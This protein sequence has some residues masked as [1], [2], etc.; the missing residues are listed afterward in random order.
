MA[1]AQ[2]RDTRAFC[3]AP[4][5]RRIALPGD[6]S[7]AGA[8]AF[9]SSLARVSLVLV[10]LFLL[11]SVHPGRLLPRPQFEVQT[12]YPKIGVHTRLTDEVEEWKIEKTLAMVREMGA[13]WIVE[14]FPWAYIQPQ[15]EIYDWTHSDMVIDHAVRQG[16]TVIARIDY[17][18][19]WARPE[20]T[21]S[22]YLDPE[23]YPLYADFLA[24][25]AER[26]RD[27]VQYYIIWNEPNLIAEWGF[28]PVSPE[29][30]TELL[31]QGYNAI[32]QVA[33]EAYVLN[34]GLAPTLEQSE[35][36]MNDLVYL[37][38]MYQAGAAQYFDIMNVHAYG[39]KLPPDDPPSEDRINFNRTEL[40][41][42]LMVQYGDEAKPVM[43]TEGGWNDHPRWT[44]AVRPA[45]RVQ[46]TLRAYEKA[47]REWPW[48]M[49]ICLWQFRLPAPARNYND[50]YAFVTPEFTTRPVYDAVKR[51]ATDLP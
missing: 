44:K 45:Q 31:R 35:A 25:F 40:V 37:E 49:A 42:E 26:Y 3:G 23:A 12:N 46:Y 39:Y 36:G 50:Y 5:A 17:V 48:V 10:C 16:L 30:Y 13:S 33:P 1:V 28:R 41:R 2:Q 32:K 8:A 19:R 20:E 27:R 18:P 24:R 47:E 29:E 34:A 9:V 15:P 22:R 7:N 4:R 21:T 11:L 14:Y 38:R 51:W 6:N 43:I